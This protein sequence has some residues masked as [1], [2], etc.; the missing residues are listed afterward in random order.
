MI[1]LIVILA[2]I[3]LLLYLVNAY[4]PMA[5]PIK[6]IINIVVVIGVVIMVLQFFGIFDMG[7]S[8]FR[9]HR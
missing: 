4:I 7:T 2:V 8:D 6:K 5:E 9:Y 1:H 3:G